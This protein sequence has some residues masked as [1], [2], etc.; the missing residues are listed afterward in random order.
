MTKT[1]KEQNAET[2]TFNRVSQ[3]MITF[4]DTNY[5]INLGLVLDG[6]KHSYMFTHGVQDNKETDPAKMSFKQVKQDEL[7]K[8]VQENMMMY[9]RGFQDGQA[10][11]MSAIQTSA[12]NDNDIKIQTRG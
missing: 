10:F 1:I 7:P 8:Q 11:A 6:D 9:F 5:L 4:E 12:A 2:A 3:I